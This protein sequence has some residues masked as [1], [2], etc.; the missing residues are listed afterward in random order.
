MRN[1][2]Q[3][4]REKYPMWKDGAPEHRSE[5]E[6]MAELITQPAAS[7]ELLLLA[8]SPICRL[9]E[10]EIATP[11]CSWQRTKMGQTQLV[12][13]ERWHFNFFLS[14]L[15]KNSKL[16]SSSTV[17]HI[18]NWWQF[19]VILYMFK[20]LKVHTVETLGFNYDRNPGLQCISNKR[21]HLKPN[22]KVHI[23]VS[24][25]SSSYRRNLTQSRTHDT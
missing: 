11:N 7:P 16:P 23:D 4:K 20:C 14:P 25:F 12:M 8:G 15:Q 18:N 3:R 17:P 6:G 13:Q 22:H 5:W 2:Q 21:R 24:K 9:S 19:C 10:I 1:Q